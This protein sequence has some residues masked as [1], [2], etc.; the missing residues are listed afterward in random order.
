V[1][2]AFG[3]GNTPPISVTMGRCVG[4]SSVITGGV[5]FRTPEDVLHTW[6]HEHGLTELTPEGL[7]P[8]FTAVEGALEVE[9]VPEAMRSP[10]THLFAAGAARQG[11][12]A[13]PT[14]RN[15]KGC[16]GRSMCN[17]GCPHQAKR[18]VDLNYLPRAVSAGARIVSRTLVERV[19]LNGDRV[20]G[21]T[22]RIVDASGRRRGRITV[23]APRVIL[24]A[25]AWHTPL[26]LQ[27][28]GIG[29][30]SGQVGRNL[31]V[32]PGFRM[33]A[34]FDEPVLGW[35]GALQS[36]FVDALHHERITLISVFVPPSVLLSAIPGVG[37]RFVDGTRVAPNLAVFG[38]IIHDDGG[39][40]L[41]RFV[42]REPLA[43]YRMSQRDRAL[44]PRVMRVLAET[45]FAAGAREAFMPVLGLGGVS[46]DRLKSLDLEHLPANSIEC[47]SQHPLGSCRMGTSPSASVVDPEGECWEVKNLFLADSSIVPTS[48]GVNPQITVMAMAARVAWKIR[49]RAGRPGH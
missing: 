44:V 7:D 29:R 43:F 35:Q 15:T 33:V 38:G 3:L 13:K 14:R 11:W 5:C 42:G 23:R 17:F 16:Q 34:R 47:V 6:S 41:H 37:P 32:H 10:S 49:E 30:T 45:F 31:T 25:G 48:L 21:V 39:G 18:S 40:T 46:P 19:E 4:G 26:I 2:P 27:R 20:A 28:S 8:Y 22:G 1:T 12:T 36:A 24:A 9:T